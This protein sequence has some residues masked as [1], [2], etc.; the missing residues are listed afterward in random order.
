MQINWRVV[1]F[2]CVKVFVNERINPEGR[3]GDRS[4]SI[5]S[6]RRGKSELR[7]VGCSEDQRH[8]VS[9]ILEAR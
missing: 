2:D 9:K 4:F 3:M 5:L 6:V 1:L 8:F 7:R